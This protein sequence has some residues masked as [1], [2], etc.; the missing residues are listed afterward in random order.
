MGKEG[1]S[2]EHMGKRNITTI[3]F[4][5]DGTVLYTLEDLKDATN[6]ILKKYGYPART[7]EEVRKFVGNGIRKLI[8]RAVPAEA[9]ENQALIDRMFGDFQIYYDAHCLDQ[10]RPYDG[11]V[12]L[13]KDLKEE[14]Y[15]IAIVSNKID[16]AVKELNQHFFGNLVPVAIGEKTGVRKKP[17]P[18]TVREALKE[19]KSTPEEAVYVGDSEVDLETARNSA[20]PCISVLW[21]FRDR[22]FLTAHGAECFAEKPSD[23]RRIVEAD[24]KYR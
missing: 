18:D 2:R 24:E 6:V 7:L 19:L 14:G 10:T 4:D 12:E 3:V 22:D 20:M 5:M 9:S 13:L 21:G 8:E 11:I 17:A 23:I 15:K 1:T 16:T